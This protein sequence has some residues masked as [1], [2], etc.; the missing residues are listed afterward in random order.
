MEVMLALAIL[1]G[2]IA[3]LGELVRVGTRSAVAA[4]DLSEAQV[5]AEALMSEVVAGLRPATAVQMAPVETVD[6][7]P[8]EFIFSLEVQSGQ[9][10]EL[11]AIRVV[12]QK[13]LP[14]SQR[15]ASVSLIRWMIDPQVLQDLEMQEYE[16]EL[17]QAEGEETAEEGGTP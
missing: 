8:S 15:P 13:D 12:V 11:L 2:A 10:P 14:P 1:G 16:I 3:V 6:G 9:S 5:I 17:M 4:R 7:T